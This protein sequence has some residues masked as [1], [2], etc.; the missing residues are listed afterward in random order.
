MGQ[1]RGMVLRIEKISPNDGQGL[2]TVVFLKGCPLR[3]AWCSTPESQQSKREWFYKQAKC[4]RCGKCIL[5]CPQGALSISPETNTVIRDKGKCTECFLCADACAFRAIGVYGKMMTVD[6]VMKE[7]RKESVFYFCSGGGVTLSGGDV[8]LQADFAQAILREC[9]EDCINTSAELDMYGS[10]DNVRKVMKYLNSAF[11]DIKIMDSGLHRKW[12]GV[13]N[14]SILENIRKASS[15]FPDVPLHI[16]M[17]LIPGVNNLSNHIL[18]IVEYC[19]TIPTCNCL[20]FLPYHRLGVASYQYLGRKYVFS[21]LPAV[22]E[23]EAQG[24]LNIL[25]SLKLP[26]TMEIAGKTFGC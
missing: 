4:R 22:M 15:D 19:K 9:R 13:E 21:D 12:T 14:T 18:S 20:E 6:Q 11:V 5:A 1:E 17:P 24:Y 23:E 7:I 16:R 2:R 10:Y 3:C 26:F 25:K 8:L